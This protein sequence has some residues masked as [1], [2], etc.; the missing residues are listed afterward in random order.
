ML[1]EWIAQYK[2]D[3]DSGLLI[4][5]QFLIRASGCEGEITLQMYRTKSH[6]AIFKLLKEKDFPVITLNCNSSRITSLYNDGPIF[7]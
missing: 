2:H 3:K 6:A 5:M 1:D 4:M 7:V